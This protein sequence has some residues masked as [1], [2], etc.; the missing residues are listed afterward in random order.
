M[1]KKEYIVKE[2]KTY[3]TYCIW[4]RLCKKNNISISNTIIYAQ[5]F[6]NHIKITRAVQGYSGKWS[7]L[8]YYPLTCFSIRRG[9]I[10]QY[11]PKNP[12]LYK[13]NDDYGL[14]KYNTKYLR[15]KINRVIKH[16]ILPK[17]KIKET[18][19]EYNERNK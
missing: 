2:C 8:K 4:R 18:L 10:Y 13:P 3:K 1:S 15:Q 5:V 7:K 16:N 14:D 12:F 6:N 19:L 17:L 9:K 11:N